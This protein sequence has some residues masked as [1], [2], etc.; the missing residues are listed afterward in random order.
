M[1]IQYHAY[2]VSREKQIIRGRS[3][4]VASVEFEKLESI[5]DLVAFVYYIYIYLYNQDEHT[6]RGI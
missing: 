3:G 2:T 4:S 5:R 6:T 1:C